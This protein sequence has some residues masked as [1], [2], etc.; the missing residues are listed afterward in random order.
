MAKAI[1]QPVQSRS[2][3][4]GTPIFKRAVQR[5]QL[6][7]G[8]RGDKAQMVRGEIGPAIK[9]DAKPGWVVMIAGHWPKRDRRPV[10][11]RQ[12]MRIAFCAAVDDIAGQ[13]NRIRLDF[14]RRNL[15]EGLK[16]SLCGIME[17][18]GTIIAQMRVT[19]LCDKRHRFSPKTRCCP[20]GQATD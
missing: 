19:Q 13:H 8:N 1:C 15:R 14:H 18:V 4:A 3:Q 6:Q 17:R 20:G 7:V 10:Q 16:Q 12:R 9:G 5:D 11:N 2:V